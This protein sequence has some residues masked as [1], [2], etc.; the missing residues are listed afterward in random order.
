[1]ISLSV[2]WETQNNPC[3]GELVQI[4]IYGSQTYIRD[5]FF[6]I[7]VYNISGGMVSSRFEKIHDRFTL[8]TVFYWIIQYNFPQNSNNY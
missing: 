3:S 2:T 8:M 5:D 6:Y 1:M 4:S 7:L